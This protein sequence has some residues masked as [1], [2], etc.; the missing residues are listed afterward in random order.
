[1]ADY[2]GALCE[3]GGQPPIAVGDPLAQRVDKRPVELDTR[4]PRSRT[5][6]VVE[7]NQTVDESYYSI[8]PI[9]Q[10]NHCLGP[11]ALA[12]SMETQFQPVTDLSG[13]AV[14]EMLM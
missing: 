4:I 1:M 10:G 14:I 7:N 11:E 8:S 6:I 13:P 5:P 2:Q 3:S 9:T 12:D